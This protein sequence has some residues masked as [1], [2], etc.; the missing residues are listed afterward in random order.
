MNPTAE[1]RAILAALPNGQRTAFWSRYHHGTNLSE[2]A[3]SMHLT[4]EQVE[5][6]LADARST[7]GCT[8]EEARTSAWGGL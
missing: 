7:V 5:A 6:L 4:M 3:R 8:P 1:Q 2:I